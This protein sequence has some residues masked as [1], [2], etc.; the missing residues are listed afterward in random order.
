[1]SKIPLYGQKPSL[2]AWGGYLLQAELLW[3]WILIAV[4]AISLEAWGGVWT[5]PAWMQILGGLV[6]GC[7]AY[8]L[9]R[10]LVKS[11]LRWTSRYVYSRVGPPPLQFR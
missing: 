7:I 11:F 6:A 2:P 3:T 8:P 4:M 1:M 5:L 9:I 10:R